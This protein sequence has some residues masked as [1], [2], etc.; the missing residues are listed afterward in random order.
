VTGRILGVDAVFSCGHL[1]EAKSGCEG[2]KQ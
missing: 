2:R 1:C